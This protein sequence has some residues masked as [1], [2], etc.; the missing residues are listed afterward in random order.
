M[1]RVGLGEESMVRRPVPTALTFVLAAGLRQ[2]LRGK[3]LE[4]VSSASDWLIHYDL[5][6]A[7]VP[8]TS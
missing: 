3:W 8:S 2:A 1:L 7:S 5:K 4:S 6:V